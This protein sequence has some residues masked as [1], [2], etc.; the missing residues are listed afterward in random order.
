[1]IVFACQEHNQRKECVCDFEGKR[2]GSL[3]IMARSLGI[4]QKSARTYAL[5]R[6]Y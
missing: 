4:S 3:L 1:L 6:G 2:H 5:D